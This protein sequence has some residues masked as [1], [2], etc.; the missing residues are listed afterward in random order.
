MI[1]SDKRVRTGLVTI[2]FEEIFGPKVQE[3]YINHLIILRH[4]ILLK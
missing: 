3:K 2:V 4:W 1:E